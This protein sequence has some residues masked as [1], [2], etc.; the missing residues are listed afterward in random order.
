MDKFLKL[1]NEF[2]KIKIDIQFGGKIVQILDKK[3]NIDWVWFNEKE[4]SNF[5][6]DQFSDY[7]SQWIGGYEELFPNDKIE[8]LN[9]N[10]LLIMESWSS[11]WNINHESEFSIDLS[12][13]G[14]FSNSRSK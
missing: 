4:Y 10:K 7:D 11:K 1:E 2:L 14:Y 6:P 8:T 3:N 12:C 5:K 9:S 13:K